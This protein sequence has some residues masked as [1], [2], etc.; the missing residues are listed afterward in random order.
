MEKK[1]DAKLPIVAR[2]H[3]EVAMVLGRPGRGA[4]NRRGLN[5]SHRHVELS[6]GGNSH[7]IHE[8]VR[9]LDDSGKIPIMLVTSYYKGSQNRY[10]AHHHEN[11]GVYHLLQV[12]GT[13]DS[14]V[15]IC[16]RISSE[17]APQICH[18]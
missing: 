7:K 4:K 6:R 9:R 17:Y 11:C 12:L 2:S 16:L 15:I 14:L 18:L 10:G 8:S 5:S 13:H 1:S 3:L